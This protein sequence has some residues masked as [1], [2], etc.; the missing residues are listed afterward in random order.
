MKLLAA[1]FGLDATGSTRLPGLLRIALV[2]LVWDCWAY[3][4]ILH[5][6]LQPLRVGLAL[7][8]Y[9]SS[10]LL[11]VG[12]WTPV[13]GLLTAASLWGAILLLGAGDPASLWLSQ[14]RQLTALLMVAG[15]LSPW[16]RSLSLDRW[17]A[18]RRSEA[19]ALSPPPERGPLWTLRLSQIVGAL[20][21]LASAV[22][23]SNAG[24]LQ[25]E[26]FGAGAPPVWA[27]PLAALLL[28]ANAAGALGLWLAR[29]RAATLVLVGAVYLALPTLMRA[30]DV[31]FVVLWLLAAWLPT[32]RV[33]DALDRL[34]GR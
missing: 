11:L 19:Q 15:A 34:H 30:D 26:A 13:A 16:G 23:Q 31:S 8:F 7:L 20:V 18:L 12:L 27:P 9:A 24:W 17:R 25:G 6:D 28:A 33:H 1:F 2:L 14:P 3:P 5:F 21:F 10:T 29:T 4:F 22:G 32:D